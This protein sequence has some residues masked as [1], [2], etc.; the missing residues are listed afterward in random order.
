MEKTSAEKAGELSTL[1][2]TAI[3][4]PFE[5]PPTPEAELS[6][7]IE[8]LAELNRKAADGLQRLRTWEQMNEYRMGVER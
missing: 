4:E 5:K 7:A 1:L 8:E 2:F 3:N 6:A